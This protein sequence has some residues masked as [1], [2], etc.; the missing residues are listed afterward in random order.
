[1]KKHSQQQRLDTMPSITEV[2]KGGKKIIY[3]VLVT[4]LEEWISA[5]PSLQQLGCSWST[6]FLLVLTLLH[7]TYSKRQIVRSVPPLLKV[8]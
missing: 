5:I 4:F 2:R 3:L 8:F 1:M 7:S 6:F